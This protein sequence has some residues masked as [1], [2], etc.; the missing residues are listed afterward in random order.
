MAKVKKADAILKE[1]RIRV[2]Q[3][4][5]IDDW[6]SADIISQIVSKWGLEERTAYRYLADARK[7]WVKE[8][9]AQTEH[10]RRLK[11]ESL[12]KL[13]RS[14]K[15]AFKGTPAGIKAV[16]SVEKEIITLENLRPAIKLEHS[17]PGGAPIQTETT[18]T[19]LILPSNGREYKKEKDEK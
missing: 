1:Q 2:V 16:L 15:D 11:I 12:K 19:V 14:L 18:A 6:P 9:L 17:G 8:S 4:W 3:E 13:K 10:R 7:K 5:I